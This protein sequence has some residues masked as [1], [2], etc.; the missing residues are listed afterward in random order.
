MNKRK[1]KKLRVLERRQTGCKLQ[2]YVK[3]GYYKQEEKLKEMQEEKNT[4]YTCKL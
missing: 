2:W 3:F 4:K 1:R